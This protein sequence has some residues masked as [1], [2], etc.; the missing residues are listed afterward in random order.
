MRQIFESINLDKID[1]RKLEK[2]SHM[3]T[4]IT[5]HSDMLQKIVEAKLL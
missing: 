2:V 1:E 5:F 4:L 3:V